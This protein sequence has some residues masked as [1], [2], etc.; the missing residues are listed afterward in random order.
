MSFLKALTGVIKT[1]APVAAN[2]VLPGAGGIVG[3]L[4]DEVL[5]GESTSL[6]TKAQAIM[7]DPKLLAELK[8]KAMDLDAKIAEEV[9][10]NR[11]D[12]NETMRA[13]LQA[14]NWW[15]KGWRPFNGYMFP[16][17]VLAIYVGVPVFNLYAPSPLYRLEIDVPEVLW[18]GWL[19]I[20][21][22]AVHGRN[23]EKLEAK[24]KGQ[25]LGGL[26]GKIIKR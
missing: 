14:G 22:I 2:V 12:I 20:L 17:A 9:T 13:E 7:N 6:E 25:G 23:Q 21:G 18:M 3:G 15:Q 16:L 26:L 8:T 11:K 5:P 19:G 10:K 1:V 4:I 24:A